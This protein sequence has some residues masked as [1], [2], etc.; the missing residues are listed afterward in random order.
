VQSA[1]ILKIGKIW[2]SCR[3]FKSGNFLRHSVDRTRRGAVVDA[4]FGLKLPDKQRI[5]DAL[6]VKRCRREDVW[7]LCFTITN[8]LPRF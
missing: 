8:R 4:S 1:N 7:K 6:Y 3:E 2:P 5:Y